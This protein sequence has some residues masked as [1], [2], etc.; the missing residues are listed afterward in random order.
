MAKKSKTGARLRMLKARVSCLEQ[1]L[2]RLGVGKSTSEPAQ[3]WRGFSQVTAAVS[4]KGQGNAV[5]SR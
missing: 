3:F 5:A 1:E 4:S 2:Q